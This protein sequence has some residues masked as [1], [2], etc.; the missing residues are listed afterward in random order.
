[1]LPFISKINHL[2]LHEILLPYTDWYFQLLFGLLVKLQNLVGRTISLA[3]DPSFET[4]GHCQCVASLNLFFV[5][6][7]LADADADELAELVS[8]PYF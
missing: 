6:F 2:A 3:L 1:M 4:L 7:T 5:S 8:L